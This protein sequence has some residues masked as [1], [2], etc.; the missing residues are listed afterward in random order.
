MRLVVLAKMFAR[1]VKAS[2]HRRDTGVESLGN[3][4]MAATFL[5][6]REQSPILRPE[7]RQRMAEGVEFLGIHRAGRFRNVFML[8]TKG[9]KNPPQLLPAQLIDTRVPREPE[10]PRLEL[11]GCLQ[12]IERAN[13]LDEHL[14][15][16]I[17]DVITSTG[18]GVNEAGDP[19]LVTDNELPLGGFVALLGPPNEVGQRSR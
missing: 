19:M 3:L 16:Q 10:Q 4:R 8:F 18:H 11:R 6:Q 7:L 9:E 5:N 2:F 13:H 15:R 17:L 14:L 12:A 1:A